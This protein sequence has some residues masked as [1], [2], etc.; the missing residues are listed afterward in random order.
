MTD[1]TPK[2]LVG[3]ARSTTE[4]EAPLV[5]LKAAGEEATT[6]LARAQLRGDVPV[7]QDRQ[8]LEQLYRVP[9]DRPIG[10][11]LF[12][13]MASLLTHVLTIDRRDR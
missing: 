6:L 3:I 2:R 1:A 7:V 13:V 9:L 4:G 10:R 5:M 8:L 12:T 11:E